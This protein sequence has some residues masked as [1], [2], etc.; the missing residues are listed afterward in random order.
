MTENGTTDKNTQLSLSYIQ[1]NPT[2]L[3]QTAQV[4]L[5]LPLVPLLLLLNPQINLWSSCHAAINERHE[6]GLTFLCWPAVIQITPL[7]PPSPFGHVFLEA[8]SPGL[9]KGN[10][11]PSFTS[12]QT[13]RVKWFRHQVANTLRKCFNTGICCTQAERKS[14]KNTYC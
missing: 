14:T 11:R 3:Y 9:P 12:W 7:Q 5:V 4:C 10:G 2:V 13:G 1:L 8:F 6:A